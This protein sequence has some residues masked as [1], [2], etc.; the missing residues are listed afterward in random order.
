MRHKKFRITVEDFLLANRKASREE[1]I[2]AHGKQITMRHVMQKSKKA[3]D[4]KRQG[5]KAINED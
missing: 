4:R 5:K 1:E 3:Y 2:A